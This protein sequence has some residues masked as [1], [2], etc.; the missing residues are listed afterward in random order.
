MAASGGNWCLIESDPGVFSELIKEFGI[1]STSNF[2]SSFFF[3][4][5]VHIFCY[6][7]ISGCKGVEVEELWSL[8]PEQFKTLK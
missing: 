8:E 3:G 2:F 5:T 1:H 7:L 6:I 4:N